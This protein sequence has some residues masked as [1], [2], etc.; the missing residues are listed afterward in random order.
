VSHCRTW[1]AIAAALGLAGPAARA[2]D[3]SDYARL[4]ER[5][6]PAIVHVKIVLKTEFD[7]G[8]STQDQESA[9]DARGAV[10][11]PRGLVLLWNSQL[12]AGRLL[13]AAEQMNGGEGMQL[14]IT[15]TDF[16]V[17]IPGRPGE[18]RAFL[19]GADSD[20]DLAFVQIEDE[21]DRPLAAIDFDAARPARL[22]ETVIGVS[23]LSPSFDHA[24]FFETARIAGEVRKPRR[25]WVLDA[26]PA[27]LGLPV[28]NLRGEPVGVVATVLSRVAESAPHGGDMMDFFALG[29]GRMESGPLGIFLL[30]AERVRGVVAAARKRAA[31]LLAERAAAAAAAPAP[32]A[33]QPP[34]AVEQAP[35]P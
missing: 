17:A 34:A 11:D 35:P 31:E 8:G 33:A 5:V 2:D 22:G 6:A 7:F 16:R 15:P 29:R 19:A 32:A 20:L 28:F 23:R 30:P 14:K 1:I 27:L 10:V 13:E 4:L 24:A 3:A 12:S 25:A 18:H 9:L 26:S 21:L